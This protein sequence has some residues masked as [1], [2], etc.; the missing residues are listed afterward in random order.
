[1]TDITTSLKGRPMARMA[2]LFIT[3]IADKSC[4]DTSPQDIQWS[5]LYF[6]VGYEV[7]RM[8]LLYRK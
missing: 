1:M 5:F 2:S 3:D 7:G 6:Y 4:D 8:T